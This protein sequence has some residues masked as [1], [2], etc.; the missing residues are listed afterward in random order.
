MPGDQS[1]TVAMPAWNAEPFLLD[2]ARSVLA[3]THAD[4]ELV[5]ADDGST[6]GTLEL[7]RS[8]RDP[9][10]TVLTGPNRG[11]T[12][13]RN[14]AAAER[15][16]AYVA[17]IDADDL[18]D[19]DK[20]A[21]QLAYLEA[22]PELAGVGSF[23]RYISSRGRVLG[24]TGTAIAASDRGRIARAEW[25]PFPIS[26][27]LVVRRKAFDAVG[28]FDESLREGEDID[29]LSRLARHAPIACVP[30][31]LGSYRIHP[32]SSMATSQQVIKMHTRFVRARLARRD[33]GG[34]LAWSEFTASYAP[35]WRDRLRD[36]VEVWYRSAALWSGEGKPL[37]ALGYGLLAALGSPLYTFR[38][39]YLQ[40][41]GRASPG[42][43]SEAP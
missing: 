35:T 40:R 37:R 6:D 25:V 27:C 5:I 3:Q 2:A 4:L 18:W 43:R 32:A 22:H 8:I 36:R 1:V 31:A 20:L 11:K 14:R 7:A 16:S 17:L 10:V 9:R 26:S 30:R 39:L 38:R 24:R 29:F 28:G 41:L 15:P 33:A 34:D 42:G 19:P 13:T 21:T 12:H 23:M